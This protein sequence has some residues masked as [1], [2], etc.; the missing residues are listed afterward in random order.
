MLRRE[1]ARWLA[2]LQSRREADVEG[3]FRRWYESDARHAEAFDRVNRSYEQAGLLRELLPTRARLRAAARQRQPGTPP[4]ALAAAVALVLLVPAAILVGTRFTLG[5]TNAVMLSTR[6][7]EIRQV[8]LS[9]G[10]KITLDTATRVEI[11]IGRSLRKARLTHGRARFEVTATGRPFVV[12][13]GGATVTTAA[14]MVDVARDEQDSHV[15]VLAGTAELRESGAAHAIILGAGSG[16]TAT[17]AGAVQKHD[18]MGEGD[19]TRGMLHFAGTPL[20]LAVAQANLYS[21]RH[22]LVEGDL[23]RL[24]VTGAF[25]SGDTAGLARALAEAFHLS[26]RQSEDGSLVLSNSGSHKKKGG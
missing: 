17:P 6:V 22:I 16:A 2:R 1:A 11:D 3:S 25:H 13:A 24:R 19:W 5:N 12:E 18:G 9:D 7:G 4:Y 21:Q 10:S 15:D 26:L 23:A 8:R 14:G 20:P